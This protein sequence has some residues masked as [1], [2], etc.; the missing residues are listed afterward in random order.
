[1]ANIENQLKLDIIVHR[2][3]ENLVRISAIQSQIELSSDQAQIEEYN[4]QVNDLLA[5][6]AALEELRSSLVIL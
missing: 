4:N 1:M 6:N 5:S 3:G 2:H